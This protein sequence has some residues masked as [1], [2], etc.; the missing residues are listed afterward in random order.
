MAQNKKG[1]RFGIKRGGIFPNAGVLVRNPISDDEA[2]IIVKGIEQIQ[3]TLRSMGSD[4]LADLL[5]A[6]YR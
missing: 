5:I 3:R 4:D 2:V 1:I 6:E